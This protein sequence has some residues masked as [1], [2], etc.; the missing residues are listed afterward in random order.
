[1]TKVTAG[2]MSNC[3]FGRCSAVCRCQTSRRKSGA[4][5]TWLLGVTRD[6]HLSARTRI[7]DLFAPGLRASG[8]LTPGAAQLLTPMIEARLAFLISCGTGSGKPTLGYRTQTGSALPGVAP[9]QRKP[10]PNGGH[11]PDQP[12]NLR[13]RGCICHRHT[14]VRTPREMCHRRVMVTS[15]HHLFSMPFTSADATTSLG[16]PDDQPFLGLRGGGQG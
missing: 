12:R 3:R 8:S 11:D 15:G 1:M 7:A 10:R 2:N 14:G 13:R 9:P 16:F 6:L 5:R 4:C